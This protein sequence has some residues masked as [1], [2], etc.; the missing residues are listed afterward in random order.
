MTA[1]LKF[2]QRETVAFE[3]IYAKVI[4]ETEREIKEKK[5][6]IRVIYRVLEKECN[7]WN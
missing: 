6:L 3:E 1:V 4:E 5:D 2:S 7:F